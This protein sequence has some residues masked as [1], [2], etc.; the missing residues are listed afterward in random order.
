MSDSRISIGFIGA[1]YMGKTH[2]AILSKDVRA[3]VAAFYDSDA[4]R[5][6]QAASEFAAH[7][8]AD[9]KEL[10]RLCDAVYI[11]LPNVRHAEMALAAI[12]ARKHVFCEKPMATN[13][14]D[15]RR[16]FE[17]AASLPRLF[18]VGH[19]RRFAPVYKEAH[20]ALAAG[21]PA[22]CAELKMNRGEL[23]NPPWTA[24]AGVTGGFLYETPIH[25]L[26]MGNWLFGP[27]EEVYAV[28]GQRVYPQEDTFSAVL[29]YPNCQAAL[30]TCAYSGWSFPFER[31]EI[32]GRG[33]TIRTEE[34]EELTVNDKTTSFRDLPRDERWGYIEEDRLF[35]D[36]VEA[37]GAAPVAAVTARSGLNSVRAVE[38]VYES[39]RTGKAVRV[40]S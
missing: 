2:A 14:A 12:E 18:Q 6:G 9:A 35:L 23:E 28:G 40:G 39:L 22:L 11:T 10:F 33:Y 29:Q 37:G 34:M 3:R 1:G 19:N 21:S 25:I 26:D 17:A 5:A 7:A 13:L 38:A 24:D 30:T 32:Y 27:L 8:A 31:L 20:K 4:A 15:A 16:I 36:A